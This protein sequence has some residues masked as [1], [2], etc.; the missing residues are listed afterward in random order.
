[1]LWV[2]IM[3]CIWTVGT[4][5]FIHTSVSLHLKPGMLQVHGHL[6]LSLYTYIFLCQRNSPLPLRTLDNAN[7]PRSLLY[8][9]NWD[10]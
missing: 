7:G 3:Q 10:A 2:C 4:V 9:S 8:D 6:V 5:L 1:M